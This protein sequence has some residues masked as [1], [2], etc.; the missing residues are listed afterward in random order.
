MTTLSDMKIAIRCPECGQMTEELIE[1]VATN[2]VIP[3]S[4]CQGL[5][6]LSVDECQ[7][8]VDLARKLAGC[9]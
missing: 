8:Q 3:C 2:G 4:I 1:R 6:D 7:E 9:P 5:I